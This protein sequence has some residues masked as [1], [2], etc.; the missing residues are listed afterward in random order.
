M[1]SYIFNFDES[2][3]S[4]E[5]E[6]KNDEIGKAV[7]SAAIEMKNKARYN[8]KSTPYKMN[9]IA[10]KGII[11]GTLKKDYKKDPNPKVKLHAFGNKEEGRLAR[12]F[13]GGTTVRINKKG[14][15]TGYIRNPEAIK[16]AV[17]Q[18]I[19][20]NKITIILNN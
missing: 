6:Q 4:K 13:V 5:A 11:L 12:I 19:L 16:N 10:D 8:L 7:V 15:A 1:M 3:L 9:N 14:K 17:D 2:L 20:D 18:S